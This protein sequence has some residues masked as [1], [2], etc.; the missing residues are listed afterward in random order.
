MDWHILFIKVVVFFNIAQGLATLFVWIERKG[1]ALIQD[2]IG[3]NRAGAEFHTDVLLLKPFLFVVRIAGIL[4]LVNTLLCDAVKALLKEDFIPEGTS[5]FVHSLAPFMGAFP[6]FL[7][8]ALVPIAP[9][10]ELFGR[11]IR[12]QIASLNVGVLFILAMGSLAVYGVVI[13]AWCSNNKFSLLG[14]LRA[15]A[16]MISYE[17]PLGITMVTMICLLYTSDAADDP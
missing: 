11:V 15:S 9:E 14:G 8:Y 16:Q 12:P 2:R 4:G 1:S 10:F 6:V 17:L 3:A 7:A 5:N 13:A